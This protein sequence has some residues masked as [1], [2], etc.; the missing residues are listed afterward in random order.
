M[1]IYL[2]TITDDPRTL[3]K[4]IPSPLPTPISAQYNGEFDKENPVVL[5]ES[6]FSDVNYAYIPDAGRYYYI[7]DIVQVRAGLM[8]LQLSVDVLQSFADQIDDAS[9]YAARTAKKKIPG[10]PDF[11]FN[12]YLADPRQPVEVPTREHVIELGAFAWGKQ[13]LVTMG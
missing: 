2:M 8:Q 4:T 10:G 6:A 7:D 12:S 5:I 1:N 9:V 11:G 13:I 3:H